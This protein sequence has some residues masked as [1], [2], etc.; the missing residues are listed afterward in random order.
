MTAIFQELGYSP[1]T[2]RFVWDA[3]QG[4]VQVYLAVPHNE[5]RVV[6]K[7]FVNG[8]KMSV[9][10][11]LF[12]LSDNLQ[13]RGTSKKVLNCF[14]DQYQ[15]LGVNSIKVHANLDVGG[16]TWCR[17]GFCAEESE[18]SEVLWRVKHYNKEFYS[19]WQQMTKIVSDFY[20][21]H[22]SDTLFPMN[23]LTDVPNAK[24]ILAGAS[25]YGE[26]ELTNPVQRKV[27]EKYLGR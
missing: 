14:Y 6:R 1:T 18:V 20:D 23:L 2:K 7:F 13:G 5:I 11:S 16:Y 21:R 24:K 9:E 25:W 3:D 26:L 10:H 15:R 8:D 27:F 12:E 22:D 19:E 4:T 17:Y